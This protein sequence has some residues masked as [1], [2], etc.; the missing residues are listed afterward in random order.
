MKEQIG[1]P[2]EMR[3]FAYVKIQPKNK[4]KNVYQ[5]AAMEKIE[6]DRGSRRKNKIQGFIINRVKI[7]WTEDVCN[8][9]GQKEK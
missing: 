1:L 7:G 2:L 9:F 5:P 3:G 6:N 8:V 4:L